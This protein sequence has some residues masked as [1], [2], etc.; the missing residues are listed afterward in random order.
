MITPSVKTDEKAEP[1]HDTK[2]PKTTD[3]AVTR[4]EKI[5]KVAKEPSKL[6]DAV[7]DQVKKVILQDAVTGK[8][9][10]LDKLGDKAAEQIISVIAA[11]GEKAAPKYDAKIQKPADISVAREDKIKKVAKVPT[12]PKDAALDETKKILP[13]KESVAAAPEISPLE[14]TEL[15][16]DK[17][18]TQIHSGKEEITRHIQQKAKKKFA[19]AKIQ[20]LR[21]TG[22]SIRLDE[23]KK[24]LV[25]KQREKK[26]LKL[27]EQMQPKEETS[28]FFLFDLVE[29][30]FGMGHETSDASQRFDVAKDLDSVAKKLDK[31]K[32]YSDKLITGSKRIAPISFTTN[33]LLRSE[34]ELNSVQ[35]ETSRKIK[36]VSSEL[37]SELF[38]SSQSSDISWRLKY[39]GLR[40]KGHNWDLSN[41]FNRVSKTLSRENLELTQRIAASKKVMI[42]PKNTMAKMEISTR[43]KK[44][45][46]S[47][48]LVVE[49]NL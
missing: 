27:S 43:G 5:K 32:K 15:L 46:V 30:F 39:L 48:V 11:K 38:E 4:E 29:S 9:G 17:I 13:K 1:T 44:F 16:K 23:V 12:K 40:S 34:K 2:M 49:E 36:Y 42:D 3:S 19:K 6:K 41:K 25:D 28:S 45:K 21:R 7:L 8:V 10:T 33:Q 18:S 22:V 47:P 37:R 35:F 20:E 24:Q 14:R 26:L 31:E